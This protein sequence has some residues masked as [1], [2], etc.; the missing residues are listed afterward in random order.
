MIPQKQKSLIAI[1]LTI[2]IS[3]SACGIIGQTNPNDM[4]PKE[5]AI[6]ANRNYEEQYKAYLQDYEFGHENEA[7]Q[8][9]L[10]AKRAVLVELYPKLM[11]FNELILM[12]DSPTPNTINEIIRLT[13]RLTGIY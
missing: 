13:Y 10:K 2:L 8:E 1:Y 5:V 6:W 9:V 3:L 7:M 12:G 4:S 11:A